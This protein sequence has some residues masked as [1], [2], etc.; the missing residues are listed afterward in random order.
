MIVLIGT[1]IQISESIA[2]LLSHRQ[3]FHFLKVSNKSEVATL[4][5]EDCVGDAKLIIVNLYG[6]YEE[7]VSLI[8]KLRQI[9]VGTPIVAL[10]SHE[11]SA[12][13]QHLISCGADAYFSI[14]AA[15]EGLN[16]MIEDCLV[17]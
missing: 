11:S 8:K 4:D 12:L 6:I 9:S 5:L 2:D 17:K 3:E 7:G 16:Q 10:D 14:Y 1:N 13:S 15:S